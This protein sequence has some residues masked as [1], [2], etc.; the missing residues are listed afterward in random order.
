M[1]LE[2]LGHLQDAPFVK[3]KPQLIS[4]DAKQ[5]GAQ[6]NT[7]DIKLNLVGNGGV[8]ASG[9]GS[10]WIVDGSDLQKQIDNIISRLNAAKGTAVCNG[11]GTI[12]FT[13]TI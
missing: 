4:K 11:D 12:T 5:N 6:A 3:D 13:L 7:P 10:Q 8:Q 2:D 1:A 9:S